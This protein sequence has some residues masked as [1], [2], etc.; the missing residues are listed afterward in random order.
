M[1]S[2][3]TPLPAEVVSASLPADSCE[4]ARCIRREGQHS[5]AAWVSHS[6]APGIGPD[7]RALLQL[8]VSIIAEPIPPLEARPSYKQLLMALSRWGV[9]VVV[10]MHPSGQRVVLLS[11]GDLLGFS[12]EPD[13]EADWESFLDACLQQRSGDTL[14]MTM[15]Q[16]VG[17][18]VAL[19]ARPLVERTAVNAIPLLSQTG[20]YTGQCATLAE[21][22][23]LQS[24]GLR[25]PRIGGMATPLGVYLTTGRYMAGAGVPGLLLTGLSFAALMK[26]GEYG[27]MVLAAGL[28]TA[29]PVAWLPAYYGAIQHSV[30]TVVLQLVFLLGLLAV[31]VRFSPIAGWHAAE[32]MTIHAI[33]KGHPLTVAAVSRQPREHGRCGTNL[34]VLLLGAQ[35]GWLVIESI[36]GAMPSPAL[37]AL[38]LGW[39]LL[40][41]SVWRRVGS[42]VQ[43]YITTK[44]PSPAQLES[45]IR[46]GDSLLKR[47]QQV[48][49]TEPTWWMRLWGSGLPVV[50]GSYLLFNWLLTQLEGYLWRWLA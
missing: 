47:F 35:T 7:V 36:R 41:T 12:L 19:F 29:L 23:R 33:E 48:P 5:S 37:F 24:H 31:V 13:D 10:A 49:H 32:H 8:P 45:G 20:E 9:A 34:M 27:F 38:L 2:E 26:L 1:S 25:P 6:T 50:L 11:P 30:Y 15:A 40:L 3:K 21:W 16:T 22:F 17:D 44:P 4:L 46:A 39:L 14:S 18:A 28:A 43:R 42:W